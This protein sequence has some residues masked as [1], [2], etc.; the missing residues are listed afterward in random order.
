MRSVLS[1]LA[2]VALCQAATS[3]QTRPGAIEGYV[4]DAFGGVL[5]G[6]TIAVSSPALPAARTVTS[7]SA[8]RF[9]LP[10][11]PAGDY[12]LSFSLSGFRTTRGL[13]SVKPPATSAVTFLMEIGSLSELVTVQSPGPAAPTQPQQS[14]VGVTPVRVG[15]SIREP[16][17]IRDVKPVYSLEAQAAGAE[18][19]VRIEA[20][21]TRD[22]QVSRERVVQ[23]VPLLNEAALA[24]VRQW[25]YTPTTLDGEPVE[26]AMSVTVRFV[27]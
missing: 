2:V 16:R 27:R 9:V 13:V 26:V 24:A 5:P 22:G 18:G 12:T 3:V 10:E 1:A 20:V 15:G 23:G 25:R 8:G 14:A 17:K 11:L 19:E 21:I 4:A 6:V 7:N